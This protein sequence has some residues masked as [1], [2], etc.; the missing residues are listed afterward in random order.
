MA[1]DERRP[2]PATPSAGPTGSQALFQGVGRRVWGRSFGLGLGGA[3]CM[4]DV[5]SKKHSG[6]TEKHPLASLV[7]GRASP[8]S[9]FAPRACGRPIAYRTPCPSALH[10]SIREHWT[11][12]S[13]T[14]HH[15]MPP[16]G[17]DWPLFDPKSIDAGLLAAF[18]R[19]KSLAM[20]KAM[21]GR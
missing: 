7:L 8:D 9:V 13:R 12:K 15:L 1:D 3:S 10:I 16:P 5:Q 6:L 19:P 4:Y 2:K 11:A 17:R 20:S 18:I 21:Q 14:P